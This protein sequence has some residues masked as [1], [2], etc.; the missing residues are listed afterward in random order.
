MEKVIVTVWHVKRK[1]VREKDVL[2]LIKSLSSEAKK[3]SAV[4]DRDMADNPKK[5]FNFLIWSRCS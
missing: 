2:T 5:L 4:L 3:P 1:T